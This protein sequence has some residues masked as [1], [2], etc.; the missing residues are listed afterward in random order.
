MNSSPMKADN[1]NANAPYLLINVNG[2]G[3]FSLISPVLVTN[4]LLYRLLPTVKPFFPYN[5]FFLPIHPINFFSRI[6]AAFISLVY[7]ARPMFG[8]Q[9]YI[10][11]RIYTVAF[12]YGCTAFL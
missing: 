5:L 8:R 12:V 7:D 6:F 3:V 9:S 10:P 11:I 4:D 2:G 1:N